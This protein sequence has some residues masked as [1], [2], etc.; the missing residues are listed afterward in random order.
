MNNKSYR[1]NISCISGG[2]CSENVRSSDIVAV[3]MSNP[4]L[5]HNLT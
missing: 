3:L 4:V 5:T 1:L 2:L